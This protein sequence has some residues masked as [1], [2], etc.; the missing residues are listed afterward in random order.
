MTKANATQQETDRLVDQYANLSELIRHGNLQ[1][2]ALDQAEDRLDRMGE[3]L[4][5]LT[6]S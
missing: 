3:R 2:Q 4:R 1:G 6:R 5:A